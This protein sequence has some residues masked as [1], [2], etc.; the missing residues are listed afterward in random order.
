[1]LLFTE[2]FDNESV[3]S[4]G[5]V[6]QTAADL[7]SFA[8]GK[9]IW[10]PI[11]AVDPGG[12]QLIYTLLSG[13]L[14]VGTT[15][16]L[17]NHVLTGVSAVT[18]T[19]T[20][21]GFTLVASNG[22]QT[23][24]QA[25]TVTGLYA[26]AP[27]WLIPTD[28]G[29]QPSTVSVLLQASSPGGYP[30]TY[31]LTGGSVPVGLAY[32]ATTQLLSGTM[33]TVVYQNSSFQI[34]AS[35]GVTATAATFT[36]TNLFTGP[37]VFLTTTL[38]PTVYQRAYTATIQFLPNTLTPTT[39]TIAGL[40]A[41]LSLRAATN[42]SIIGTPTDSSAGGVYT[43]VITATNSA[44]TSTQ[45][46][47]L[48]YL[49]QPVWISSGSLAAFN[50]TTAASVT[51][52]A[53]A[54]DPTDTI[55]YQIATGS[56]PP[57]MA[58]DGATGVISGAVD[59]AS[60]S[61]NTVF[62]FTV[63]ATDEAG[64]TATSSPL[65]ITVNK[66][67]APTIS[68][69]GVNGTVA[70]YSGQ[71]YS[72]TISATDPQGYAISFAC[73]GLLSG[74]TF[75]DNGNGTA[76]F[77]G[78]V[79]TT[80]TSGTYTYTVTVSNPYLSTTYHA[81]NEVPSFAVTY[82]PV[83]VWNTG[84]ADPYDITAMCSPEL[85]T[86]TDWFALGNNADVVIGGNAESGGYTIGTPLVGNLLGVS[87]MAVTGGNLPA[88]ISLG[89]NQALSTRLWANGNGYFLAGTFDVATCIAQSPYTFTI[90]ATTA[91]WTVPQNF[92]AYFTDISWSQATYDLGTSVVNSTR[93]SYSTLTSLFTNPQGWTGEFAEIVANNTFNGSAYNTAVFALTGSG[94]Y[95]FGSANA[96]YWT[97]TAALPGSYTACFGFCY[98]NNTATVSPNM[99][100]VMLSVADI[101]WSQGEIDLG[102][103][104]YSGSGSFIPL[105]GI[106]SYFANPSN[107]SGTLAIKSQSASGVTYSTANGGEFIVPTTQTGGAYSL[108][109]GFK[110]SV[111]GS[112]SPN[113][114][115]ITYTVPVAT[116]VWGPYYV[117][118]LSGYVL[119]NGQ[120]G[121]WL[122]NAGATQ[123][124]I[125]LWG[126]GSS[127]EPQNAMLETLAGHTP[128]ITLT[129]GA[130]PPN[131]SLGGLSGLYSVI[132]GT[133][134]TSA[135]GRSYAFTLTASYPGG[136]SAAASFVFNL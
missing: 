91:V 32:N 7:G 64:L 130:L 79:A 100:T 38:A 88:G 9:P 23:A 125:G 30:L 73:A 39:Y 42:C 121:P 68:G 102:T 94:V 85:I 11:S 36:I 17:L 3:I 51:L 126:N 99:L 109:I 61:A 116:P 87:S 49:T 104:T 4:S 106:S 107:L 19:T 75:T 131:L 31:A 118:D 8:V 45:T 82:A 57:S 24:T 2:G 86:Q 13:H 43:V 72:Q 50:P 129:S 74:L 117:Y 54:A 77:G 65:S 110:Y 56:L 66:I 34:T 10:L 47:A 14:P 52:L 136:G 67:T 114:L 60:S 44:G 113:T 76:S 80:V 28:L 29:Y 70:L 101:S 53:T 59:F 127:P 33:S 124:Y 16:N 6:W 115:L 122:T 132:Q 22:S 92:I 37:P 62:A 89:H 55:T 128:T 15:Y 27:I 93:L 20:T 90:T 78:S 25:F 18:T 84:G 135:R 81:G 83:P 119:A 112:Y 46:Y 5:P 123:Y 97:A 26:G 105:T 71:A 120:I 35:D 111:N 1:M 134:P 95:K 40:P 12:E 96:A 108:T 48:D 21:Y 69:G 41:G 103:V 58:L 63:V 98:Y 133:I